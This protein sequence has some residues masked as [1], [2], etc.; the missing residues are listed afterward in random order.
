MDDPTTVTRSERTDPVISERVLS[1][2]H[3]VRSSGGFVL[4]IF[5]RIE[6]SCRFRCFTP[7]RSFNVEADRSGLGRYDPVRRGGGVLQAH[8]FLNSVSDSD[9]YC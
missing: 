4:R 7:F 6:R 3:F 9:T 8:N 2:P 1:E 5:G